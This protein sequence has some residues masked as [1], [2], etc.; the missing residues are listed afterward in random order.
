MNVG[1]W[2]RYRTFRVYQFCMH[3]L[4]ILGVVLKKL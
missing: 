1:Q 3:F 2:V 4:H